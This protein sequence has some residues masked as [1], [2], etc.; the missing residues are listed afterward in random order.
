MPEKGLD[1]EE[2][3][4]LAKTALDNSKVWADIASILITGGQPQ[5]SDIIEVA[6]KT[7]ESWAEGQKLIRRMIEQWGD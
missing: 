5:A 4:E 3:L 6:A 2:R 7:G 1:A